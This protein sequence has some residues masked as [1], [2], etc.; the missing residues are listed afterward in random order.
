MIFK[1]SCQKLS[2]KCIVFTLRIK[3]VEV[4]IPDLTPPLS[5]EAV[6]KHGGELDIK[7]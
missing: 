6:M 5:L 7:I 2:N 4:V 1:Y 3:F